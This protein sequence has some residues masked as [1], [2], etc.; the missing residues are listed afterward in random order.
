MAQYQ[1]P[2]VFD[3]KNLL[4]TTQAGNFGIYGQAEIALYGG[5]GPAALEVYWDGVP[6]LP[7][8]RDSVYLD[9]ARIPLAPLQRVDVIV[10]P[11]SLRVYLVTVRHRSTQA[12]TL[13]RITTGQVRTAG[14]RGWFLKRWRSGLGLSL[15]ADYN[16]ND[17]IP[18]SSSTAFNSVDL[19]LKA[20]YL[21]SGRLG[22]SY[23]VLSSTWTRS[24]SDPPGLVDRFPFERRDAVL[25]AFAAARPDGLGPRIELTLASATISKDTA[26]TG[27][28]VSQR[29][30]TLSSAGA[31]ARAGLTARVQDAERPW[32]FEAQAAWRPVRGLTLAA[33][34]RHAAYSGSRKGDRA[35]L[36]AGL[37]LPLGFSA[38]GDLAWA[39]DLQDPLVASDTAQKVTDYSG[40]LRWDRSRGAIEVGGARRD[41]FAPI[42][43]PTGLKPFVGLAL[44]PRTRYLTVHASTQ[45]V[46]GIFLSGWYFNPLVEGGNDFE[47][48]YHA[49][50]SATFYTKFWRV[51]RSGIFALRLELAAESWSRGTAGV[52]SL[53]Q[54]VLLPGA[55]FM[56]SN[57][58]IRVAGV[59]I[60]WIQRNT[61][62]FRGSYV[63]GLDYPR[64]FQ[65]YGVRWAFTD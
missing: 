13:I 26:V 58:E 2:P 16:N 7:I 21:R 41:P 30:L 22:A 37:A 53:G 32:Q 35:H 56:E 42:G 39:H 65:F 27:R 25:R 23:Q 59:T 6:Y 60:Y 12:S 57:L 4:T 63:P 54:A 52:D 46:P 8:G 51:Y 1:N 44:T 24:P 49:R 20:E 55:T 19:W 31:H 11:A 43:R 61:N 50:L 40:A 36:A 9:P 15:A 33:D 17:G 38:H 47:P 29:M 10:L 34:G 14:Y 3:G 62:G 45:P 48:P 5:R 18:G 28:S 64:R